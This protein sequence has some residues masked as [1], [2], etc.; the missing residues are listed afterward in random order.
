VAATAVNRAD[1][2][3][4]RGLY[5]PPAGI[6]DV[7]G[8]EAAG[9]VVAVGEGVVEAGLV[10][11]RVMALLSGG[12]YAEY[13]V[14]HARHVLPLPPCLSLQEGLSALPPI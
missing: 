10:G 9:E 12:G 7:L 14:V 1:T 4:R 8:L 2:L 3:Q 5:P 6:T 11:R 13:A